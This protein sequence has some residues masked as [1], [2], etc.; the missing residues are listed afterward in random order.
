MRQPPVSYTLE[1]QERMT[2]AKNYF[3]WQSRLVM[4]E[5][6]GL[7]RLDA[8]SATSPKCCSTAIW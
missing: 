2:R 4:R 8:E 5:I 3:A 1:D 7:W 6:G